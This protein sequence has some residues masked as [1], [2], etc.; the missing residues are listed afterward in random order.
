VRRVAYAPLLRKFGGRLRVFYVGGAPLDL[1]V[2]EYFV[3][4]G[5]SVYQ[6]YGLTETS[7]IVAMNAPGANRLGSVGR[8]LPDVEVRI[9]TDVVAPSGEGAVLVR[10]PNVML[11]YHRDPEATRAT[12]DDDGWLD[13]GDLG[14]SDADGFLWITG[15]SKNVIVLANGK[16]VQPEEVEHVLE[17]SSLVREVCVLGRAATGGLADGSEEVHAVVVPTDDAKASRT[18]EEL[19][20]LMQAEVHSLTERLA[21]YKHPR[22]ITVWT[23][24]L[25][26]TA[27]RKVRRSEVGALLAQATSHPA[28]TS[29]QGNP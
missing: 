26:K 4:I 5:I 17:Q 25:P 1:D 9:D 23:H 2:A 19:Q 12:I 6:G 8:P 28:A 24:E 27:T 18:G 20:A 21:T 3:R 22:T 16:N 29:R 14:H 10:G 13:T 7:P 15:R 11:G